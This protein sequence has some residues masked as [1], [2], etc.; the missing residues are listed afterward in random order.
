MPLKKA[1]LTAHAHFPFRNVIMWDNS[2]SVARHNGH[3]EQT[4]YMCTETSSRT[5]CGSKEIAHEVEA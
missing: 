2:T 4:R 3:V 1:A 5:Q